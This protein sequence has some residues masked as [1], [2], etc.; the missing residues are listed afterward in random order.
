M[1]R[2][3][4]MDSIHKIIDTK[5]VKVPKSFV[6]FWALFMI[7]GITEET[8]NLLRLYALT[9]VKK[10]CTPSFIFNYIIGPVNLV[11]KGFKDFYQKNRL[12]VSTQKR[13]RILQILQL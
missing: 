10:F 13:G 9:D 11:L 7:L 12:C 6:V 2:A 3:F 5:K 8:T 4:R 1:D